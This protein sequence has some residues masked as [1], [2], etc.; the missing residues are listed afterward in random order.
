MDAQNGKIGKIY[1]STIFVA[2]KL[3]TSTGK[4][5]SAKVIYA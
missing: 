4:P 2:I 1:N 3:K 5:T